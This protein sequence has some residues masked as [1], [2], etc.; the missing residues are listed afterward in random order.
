MN[1]SSGCDP[2][3]VPIAAGDPVEILYWS[4]VFQ[5]SE[6]DLRGAI[7]RVGPCVNLVREEIRRVKTDAQNQTT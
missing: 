7:A 6:E 2:R 5:V 1:G 3:D 4:R